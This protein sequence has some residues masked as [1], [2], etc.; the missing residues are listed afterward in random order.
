[1]AAYLTLENGKVFKGEFFGADTSVTGEVVFTTGMTGYLE[2]LIDKNYY[3]QIIVQT[4]P[5]IG[6][7]GVIPSDIEGGRIAAK[8]YIVKDW[9]KNPSN[10]RCEGTLDAFLKSQ[11]VTGICGVDTR[12]LTRLIRENGVMNGSITKT[13]EDAD[14][15]EIKSYMVT[16]AV[17]SVSI[18]NAEF[19]KSKGSKFTVALMD[20]GMKENIRRELMERGCDVWV[21]PAESS[22]DA[23]LAVK[24]DGIILSNGPGSP[25][26]NAEIV[27]NVGVLMKSGIPMFGIC[28]GHLILASASGLKSEKM[29]YGH[30]GA[31]QPVKDLRS[32]RVFIT[33]QNHG[34]TVI[35]DSV[36]KSIAEEIY[37]NVN[38]GT[39]E[40][41][42]YKKIKAFSV[43]F[44]PGGGPLETTF[45]FDRFL[46]MMGGK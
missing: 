17:R 28:L 46:E 40:G 22:P 36:D 11:G 23:V 31:N 45:L 38:D 26:D 39:C 25:D 7:Y 18:N 5:L 34:Y 16:D 41:L 20:Y 15:D 37:V 8:A 4:F 9:C 21:F 19:S 6:N 3:G 1:M 33:G 10:F 30:R 24:P 29:K 13:P 35:P 43:Q 27:R 42:E 32:G 12:S 44:V 14:V 2:T